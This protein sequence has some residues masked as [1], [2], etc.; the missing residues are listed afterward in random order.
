M[1]SLTIKEVA[2]RLLERLPED[3]TW[4]DIEYE[5]YVRRTIESGIAES[6]A[7]DTVSVEEVRRE[8]GLPE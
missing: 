3:A 4:D 1:S 7:G 2:R 6:D 8:F 5:I